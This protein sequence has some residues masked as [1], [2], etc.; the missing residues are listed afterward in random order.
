MIRLNYVN[1]GLQFLLELFRWFRNVHITIVYCFEREVMGISLEGESDWIQSGC[2]A[3]FCLV[4]VYDPN[5]ANNNPSSF[6]PP[7]TNLYPKPPSSLSNRGFFSASTMN[8]VLTSINTPLY[9]AGL[10]KKTLYISL[11][12]DATDAAPEYR[13]LQRVPNRDVHGDVNHYEE[14]G[15]KS[16]RM[17]RTKL[18]RH[19]YDHVVQGDLEK[20]GIQ[21][22]CLFLL[23]PKHSHDL[24]APLSLAQFH[25][26]RMSSSSRTFPNTTL[27]GCTRKVMP[28]F[29]AQT[30]TFMVSHSL[31]LL[32]QRV[33]SLNTPLILY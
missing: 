1:P 4:I 27:Y 13:P 32:M 24:L 29:R 5:L 15:E 6:H 33:R 23:F 19:V 3:L 2:A 17:W 14:A 26:L 20:Q 25:I 8:R 16:D 10:D 21:R 11:K 7:L 31:L 18:G 22:A 12:D 9:E 28:T 30:P